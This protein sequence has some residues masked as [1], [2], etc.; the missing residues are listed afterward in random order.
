[1]NPDC[2]LFIKTHFVCRGGGGGL[3]EVGN[4]TLTRNG[5]THY[6]LSRVLR[7]INFGS[8]NSSNFIRVITLG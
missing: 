8:D 1:M 6:R 3:A 7:A 2:Y 4:I 5:I